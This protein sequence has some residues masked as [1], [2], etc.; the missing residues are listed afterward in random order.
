MQHHGNQ[1]EL[2]WQ[3]KPLKPRLP[4]PTRK[5]DVRNRDATGVVARF[6]NACVRIGVTHSRLSSVAIDL[7]LMASSEK[8]SK[9]AMENASLHLRKEKQNPRKTD[10]NK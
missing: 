3:P 5:A 4:E 2:Q 7:I 1:Y 8:S 9:G 6:Q 10:A